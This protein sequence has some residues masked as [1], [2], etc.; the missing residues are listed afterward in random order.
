MPG[1]TS[2][3]GLLIDR[4]APLPL[5][6]THVSDGVN[7]SIFSRN[8]TEVTLVLW[9]SGDVERSLLVPL[10][11]GSIGRGTSGTLVCRGSVRTSTTAIE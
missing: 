8:A 6:A 11:P 2:D 5:G 4:G 10:H 1:R 7:F 3:S 9:V